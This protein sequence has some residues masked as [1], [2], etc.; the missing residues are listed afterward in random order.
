[1][2]KSFFAKLNR[3]YHNTNKNKMEGA[4]KEQNFICHR[5]NDDRLSGLFFKNTL[6]LTS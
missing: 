5:P 3:I 2:K 1:M 4:M 6:G